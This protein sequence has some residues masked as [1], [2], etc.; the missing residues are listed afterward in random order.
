VLDAGVDYGQ[1]AGRCPVHYIFCDQDQAL[2]LEVQQR[3]LKGLRDAGCQ[4]QE[5]SLAAG[6]NVIL[7]HGQELAALLLALAPGQEPPTE[8]ALSAEQPVPEAVAVTASAVTASTEPAGTTGPAQA[9]PTQAVR[10][11]R[12]PWGRRRSV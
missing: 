11:R 8:G 4:G 9:G 6:H 12:W 1:L 7:T 2:P 3:M 5:R 10:R